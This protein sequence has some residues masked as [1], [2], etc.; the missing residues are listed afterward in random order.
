VKMVP[1]KR[2]NFVSFSRRTTNS[3]TNEQGK[4]ISVRLREG[5]CVC[6]TIANRHSGCEGWDK[7]SV[8]ICGAPIKCVQSS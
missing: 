6:I 4:F 2:R 8:M 3:V 5:Y 1:T 7:Q